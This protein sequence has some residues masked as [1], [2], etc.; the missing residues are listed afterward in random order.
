MST[1]TA[2]TANDAKDRRVLAVILHA[3]VMGSTELV[4]QNETLAHEK[5]LEVFNRFSK[6]IGE[7]GGLT[8]ELRGDALVQTGAV[9]GLQGSVNE[10]V[11]A[12]IQAGRFE[13][14]PLTLNVLKLDGLELYP[15]N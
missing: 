5:I 14:A 10:S 15:E 13:I 6:V 8:R 2:T 9:R 3:D 4:L 12:D 11:I 7:Y 1:S